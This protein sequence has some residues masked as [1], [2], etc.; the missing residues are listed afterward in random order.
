MKKIIW[1]PKAIASLGRL[2]KFLD[3][4]WEKKV[5]DGLLSEI[6][7]AVERISKNPFLYPLYSKKKNIRK[8]LVK[9]R[10]LLFYRATSAEILILL[11]VD[12]RQNPK[13]FNF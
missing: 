4:K 9:K 6:D 3:N 1:S 10:T 8:C 2:I 13:N 5:G 7:K 12:A 11:F